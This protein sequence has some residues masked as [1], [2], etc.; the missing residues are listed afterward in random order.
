MKNLLDTED[1]DT[2]DIDFD[3]LYGLCD[4]DIPYTLPSDNLAAELL[5]P[6]WNNNLIEDSLETIRNVLATSNIP[7][8][9]RD[10]IEKSLTTL[11]NAID[12]PSIDDYEST[13]DAEAP[14]LLQLDDWSPSNNLPD[15]ND[16]V[17]DDPKCYSEVPPESAEQEDK[18]MEALGLTNQ[19]GFYSL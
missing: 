5:Q 10:I 4:A 12:L 14:T 3:D 6:S 9:N 2:I 16:P 7:A 13:E 1:G 17:Y 11:K 19:V 8:N 18:V 15:S